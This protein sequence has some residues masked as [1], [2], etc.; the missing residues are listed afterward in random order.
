M[1][2]RP[3]PGR[4]AY[5]NALEI[6]RRRHRW[7]RC[8]PGILLAEEHLDSYTLLLLTA[9]QPE[10]IREAQ[11]TISSGSNLLTKK[12]NGRTCF[13]VCAGTFESPETAGRALAGLPGEFRS[14]GAAVRPVAD[15]LKRDR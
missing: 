9:C 10:T 6:F 12:V 1:R 8:R 15:V 7:R 5:H 13:R 11:R 14:A 2:G 3:L 4:T